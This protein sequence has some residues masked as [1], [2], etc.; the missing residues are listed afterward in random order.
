MN[1]EQPGRVGGPGGWC[2]P[3]GKAW[4]VSPG[5]LTRSSRPRGTVLSGCP[6]PRRSPRPGLARCW[7]TSGPRGNARL[8]GRSPAPGSLSATTWSGGSTRPAKHGCPG[9]PAMTTGSSCSARRATPLA[10]PLPPC[11]TWASPAPPT[12]SAATRPGR[13]LACR[14]RPPRRT[15]RSSPRARST[16]G[17]PERA[18][19]GTPRAPPWR[20]ACRALLLLTPCRWSSWRW[21][22]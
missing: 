21:P 5:E 16:R 8:T 2:V 7:W 12:S 20:K 6:R 1:G 4:C 17:Y 9:C 14:P 22:C 10:W 11:S 3:P 18:E 15:R 19:P 13:P